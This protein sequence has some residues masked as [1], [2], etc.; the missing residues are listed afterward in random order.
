MTAQASSDRPLEAL[1][2]LVGEWQMVPTL[3]WASLPV[4]SASIQPRHQTSRGDAAGRRQ[5]GEHSLHWDRGQEAQVG[6]ARGW[7]ER[8]KKRKA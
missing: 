3:A 2:Q 6:A 5:M 8:R 7:P 1:R 4:C